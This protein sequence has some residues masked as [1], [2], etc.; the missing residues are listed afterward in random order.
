ML[1]ADMRVLKA[2]KTFGSNIEIHVKLK[3]S[4]RETS[5]I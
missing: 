4:N 1:D 3:R 2:V 5:F